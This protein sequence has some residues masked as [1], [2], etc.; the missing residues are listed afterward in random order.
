MERGIVYVD[1]VATVCVHLSVRS[2]SM[3]LGRGRRDGDMSDRERLLRTFVNGR[4]RLGSAGMRR[5]YSSKFAKAGFREPSCVGLVR[6]IQTSGVSYVIMG[7]LSELK[8]SCVRINDLL[9]R[10]FPLC[11]MQIVTIGSGCSDSGC[12]NSANNVGITFGGLVCV[13]C[14]ESLSGGIDSTVRAEVLGNRGV[15]NRLECKCIGSP[16]SGRGVVISPRTTRIIGLVFR[17]ATRNGDGA[18]ITGCLGT[19]NVSAPSTCGGEGKDEGFF[20]TIRMGDL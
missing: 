16:G 4:S 2:R 20:R 9:R 11:R 8:E 14:D 1:G 15:D 17:L 10:V 3:S 19:R 13:L 18:R 5:C 6:S 12:S 7:S